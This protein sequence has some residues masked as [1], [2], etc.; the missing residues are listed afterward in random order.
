[1]K[2]N[3]FFPEVNGNLG[4]GCMRL[5]MKSGSVDYDTFEGIQTDSNGAAL[6]VHM[7]NT[8]SITIVIQD[9]AFRDN[10]AG[11]TEGLSYDGGAIFATSHNIAFQITGTNF[12]NCSASPGIL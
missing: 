12:T 9:C 8:S 5:P 6:Y 2:N 7:G 4:F 11:V 10:M 3:K 1:M